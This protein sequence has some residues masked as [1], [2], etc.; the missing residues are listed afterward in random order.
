[1][2]A[3]VN[4]IKP[5]LNER[6]FLIGLRLNNQKLDHVEYSLDELKLLVKTAGAITIDSIIIRREKID[7]GYLLGSGNIE[8]LKDLG[9]FVVLYALF[10]L[11]VY[12]ALYRTP[13][14]SYLSLMIRAAYFVVLPAFSVSIWFNRMRLFE[15]FLTSG[16]LFLLIAGIL[17]FWMNYL[18]MSIAP[19]TP[20][21]PLIFL[22]VS[23]ATK[24]IL[25]KRTPT[26]HDA[27]KQK[28]L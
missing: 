6:A 26:T 7:P 5:S 24:I 10:C 25:T 18:G 28:P 14:F 3:S 16:A 13:V 22:V 11:A 9:Y 15:K 2:D 19:I 17:F 12:L 21:L 27:P 8:I 4:R 20:W 1:M 23:V